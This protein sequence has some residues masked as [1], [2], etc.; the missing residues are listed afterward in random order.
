MAGELGF[1]YNILEG[2]WQK[3]MQ[4]ELRELVEYSAQ[5]K[6]KIWVRKHRKDLR[7]EESRRKFFAF[8]RIDRIEVLPAQRSIF[9]TAKPKRSSSF[10]KR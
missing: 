3:W 1:E 2:F 8:A 10:I 4:S 6:V 7:D 9:S 5:R